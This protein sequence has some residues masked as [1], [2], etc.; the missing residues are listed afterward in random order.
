MSKRQGYHEHTEVCAMCK[1]S[2]HVGCENAT[3]CRV[4][5]PEHY[6]EDDCVSEDHNIANHVESYGTCKSF[7][8]WDVQF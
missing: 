3:A 4:D 5:Y 6:D 7:E 1:Y 8:K 2:Q